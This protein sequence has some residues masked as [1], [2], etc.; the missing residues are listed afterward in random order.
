M[1]N[2]QM[3]LLKKLF[4]SKDATEQSKSIDKIFDYLQSITPIPDITYQYA[5]E[6]NRI[7]GD[8]KND[9]DSKF[10]HL[11]LI[12]EDFI[13]T[14]TS[15][16]INQQITYSEIRRTIR[17]KVNID[18][19]DN[20]FKLI[21]LKETRQAIY[22][23]EIF[24]QYIIKYIVKN[25]GTENINSTLK[26][27]NVGTPFESIAIVD[28]KL[29]FSTFN[30]KYSGEMKFEEATQL[31]KGLYTLLYNIIESSFGQ[32]I[33]SGFFNKIYKTLQQ[34][35]NR[36]LAAVFLHIL[37]EQVLGFDEW[38]ASL[39]K[40]E[41]ERQVAEKT[42][43]LEEL[44][45]SLEVKVKERTQE[46]QKAYDELK[47]LDK[48]KSDFISVVA[49]Q[50][51][52]P[53]SGLKWTLKMLVNEE[54]GPITEDQKKMLDQ[55]YETN[56][57]LISIVND[58]LDTDLITTGKSEF[59]PEKTSVDKILATVLNETLATAKQKEMD[60]KTNI[61]DDIPKEFFADTKRLSL[62]MQNL[63]DN[64]IKYGS[65]NTT[66]EIGVTKKDEKII[67]AVKDQ[68]IG[69][70]EDQQKNIFERFYRASNALR[71]HANGSGLGLF[72]A[73]NIIAL[74][75]GKIWF[76]SK[77]NVGT[78]FFVEF[79]LVLN[80]VTPG[81]KTVEAPDS[82][83]IDVPDSKPV[84]VPAE[85]SKVLGESTLNKTSE[86]IDKVLTNIQEKDPNKE[87]MKS[88]PQ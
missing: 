84:D 3:A 51:R 46:L 33:A 74:H 48:K 29:D 54:L 27:N 72:I 19:L 18:V 12:W 73:R 76:E 58:I 64:A 7:K 28:D 60:V 70:P 75:K 9:F 86:A 17:D 82:K 77:E 67:F 42:H 83:T 40:Q 49:H 2:N 34:I 20:K 13:I 8:A 63:V 38:L 10:I 22:I 52:T 85:E 23:Y 80:E 14:N 55:S 61:A 87:A 5:E 24:V 15:M 35:Y 11:Y 53:L 1:Y 30:E 79:P 36:D 50:L 44:N 78:T 56:D 41:L 25:S 32:E 6:Y 39:S 31:F 68:G 62:V 65:K 88:I 21:F 66:V 43:E 47:V 71:A 45:N 26:Q 57:Y 37:P 16:K 4:G 69:I 81:S 59:A